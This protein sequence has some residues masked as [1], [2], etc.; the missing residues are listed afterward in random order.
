MNQRLRG[1]CEASSKKKKY[2]PEK[3]VLINLSLEETVEIENTQVEFIAYTKFLYK[4][5]EMI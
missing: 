2:S 1:R 5:E 3:A 4:L